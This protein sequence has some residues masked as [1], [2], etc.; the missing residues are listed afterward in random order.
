MKKQNKLIVM[1][2]KMTRNEKNSQEKGNE[3]TNDDIK[4]GGNEEKGHNLSE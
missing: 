2:E 4:H 3:E 1:Q